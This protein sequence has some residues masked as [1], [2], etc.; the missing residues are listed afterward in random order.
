MDRETLDFGHFVELFFARDDGLCS[1]DDLRERYETSVFWDRRAFS[2]RESFRDCFE[3]VGDVHAF[4]SAVFGVRCSEDLGEIV[5]KNSK[6]CIVG[7]LLRV[8][9]AVSRACMRDIVFCII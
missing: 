8:V 1:L 7:L 5:T 3:G 2:E 4:E 9:V 6:W